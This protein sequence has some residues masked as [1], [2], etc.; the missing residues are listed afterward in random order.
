[1]ENKQDVKEIKDVLKLVM[2]GY[3]AVVLSMADGK[4]GLEDLAN[5][6]IVAPHIGAAFENIGEIPAEFKD[7][8]SAEAKELVDYV[9]SELGVDD[10]SRAGRII[11]HALGLVQHG[12]GMYTAITEKPEVEA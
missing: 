6:M 9:R 4:I 10:A 7:M 1:M 3:K 11:S 12:W 2:S 8:D 5:L